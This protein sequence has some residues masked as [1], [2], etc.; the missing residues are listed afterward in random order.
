MYHSDSWSFAAAAAAVAAVGKEFG[1]DQTLVVDFGPVLIAVVVQPG[2]V[3][4][5]SGPG[6]AVVPWGC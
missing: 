1:S 5:G 6:V 4:V 3:S 2:P